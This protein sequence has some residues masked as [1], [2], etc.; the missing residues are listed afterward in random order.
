MRRRPASSASRRPPFPSRRV[1]RPRSIGSFQGPTSGTTGRDRRRGPPF[2]IASASCRGGPGTGKTTTVAAI[3]SLLVEL[4]VADP[5]RIAL[6]APHRQGGGP[7]P[8]GGAEGNCGRSA[9]GRAALAAEV[10]AM[11]AF[12]AEAS[13]VHRLLARA[14][15]GPLPVDALILDEAS[16]VDLTV[17]ARVLAALP[18][19]ARLVLLGD[20]SQLASV[21]PGSVFAD[22][23]RAGREAAP[24]AACVTELVH[25]WRFRETGGI[26]RIAAAAVRGDAAAVLTAFEEPPAEA[27][28][29]AELRP[30]HGARRVRTVGEETRRRAVRAAP[31]RR[32]GAGRAR[33]RRRRSR[34]ALPGALRAPGRPVRGRALQ[35]AR[36]AAAPRARP[37]F[38][39]RSL[40]PRPA[41]PRDPQRHA[42]RPLERRHGGRGSRRGRPRP[43]LVPGATGRGWRAAPRL[44]GPPPASRELLRPHRAPGAG[45]G[46][47]GGG[48]GAGAR[49]NPGWRPREL[50]YTAVT[51]AR[52]RVVVHGSG[53]SVAAAVE[54][55]TAR[56]S[57]LHDALTPAAGPADTGTRPSLHGV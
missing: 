17:M 24:L 34:S 7:P 39:K 6:A 1:P 27:G 8:G 13:T 29:T 37:R 32:P 45:L 23:C 2:V 48:G 50:L 46:V 54:R 14:G 26:G 51:R 22:L 33:R 36:G 55:A 38:R 20:A 44:P 9:R 21:Q 30:P 25:N 56:S 5:G 3:V 28:D 57:G 52:R 15:G 41:D 40:L 49:P 18:E 10:P 35:P 19:G 31:P 4:G 43:R 42:D 47:R 53:E 12:P 16:M 11:A